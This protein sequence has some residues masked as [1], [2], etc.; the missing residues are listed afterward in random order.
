M[1]LRPAF[2]AALFLPAGLGLWGQVLQPD[3]LPY[4]MLALALLLISMEQAHMARVDLRQV[5][6]VQQRRTGLSPGDNERLT[7]FHRLVWLT[8]LG[9]LAGFYLAA[10]GYLGPGVLVILASLVG[11]NLTAG[12]RLEP[13]A[14]S[15][16]HAAGVRTRLDVLAIDAVAMGLGLLWMARLAQGWVAGGLLALVLL[17]A[18]IKVVIYALSQ[19]SLF[20]QHRGQSSTTSTTSTTSM[21][22]AVHVANAAQQHPHPSQQN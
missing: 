22:S 10:A 16:I 2:A 17:Y 11:F 9:E 19:W 18:S 21:A 3:P 8:I 20:K 13:A 14:A 12:I 4:R 1:V 7:A 15:P 5:I 6:A